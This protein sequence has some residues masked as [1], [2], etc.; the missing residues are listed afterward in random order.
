MVDLV[1]LIFL[2]WEIGNLAS[3]KGL[4][5]F[6]WRVY[7]VSGWLTGEI[8]GLAV[9]VTIFAPDNL[10]SI[11]L[12][13][14]IFGVTSYFLIKNHLNKMPDRQSTDDDISNTGK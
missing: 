5:A 9:G 8:I 2:A 11:I 13:G 7:T 10:V 4:K 14:I 3:K 1:I 6:T 12:M